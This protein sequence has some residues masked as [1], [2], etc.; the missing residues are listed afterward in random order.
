M[1][2]GALAGVPPHQILDYT[3]RMLAALL[4]ADE[5]R[6]K[7][8][9]ALELWAHYQGQSLRR[10]KRLPRLRD[11]LRK[12]FPLPVMSAKAQHHAI[13]SMA[14]AMGARVTYRKKGT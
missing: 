9:M 11:L 4:D 5:Q 7:L 6:Q 1:Q 3:H 2:A 14:K 13:M 12:F 10:Q 8:T